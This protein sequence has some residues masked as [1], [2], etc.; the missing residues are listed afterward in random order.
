MSINNKQNKSIQKSDSSSL[1]SEDVYEVEKILDDR[2]NNN[3]KQY[4]IKWLGYPLDECTWEYEENLYCDKVKF[5]YEISNKRNKESKKKLSVKTDKKDASFQKIENV[6]K[7]K[8]INSTKKISS[9]KNTGSIKMTG[10]TKK[11]SSVGFQP[12]ITNEWD[13][14]IDKITLIE[15]TENGTIEAAYTTYDGTHG[16]IDVVD[17]RYKA[18]LKLIKFYEDHM[19]FKKK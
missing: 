3:K 5:E 4:L 11:T 9:T 7:S 12:K 13:N 15:K 2:I 1:T 18:P 17:L 8:M 10:S 19:F 16:A 6:K 14:Y